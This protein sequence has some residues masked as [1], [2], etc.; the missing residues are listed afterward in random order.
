MKYVFFNK[1]VHFG[2]MLTSIIIKL[3]KL[4]LATIYSEPDLTPR[5]A[6]VVDHISP[7]DYNASNCQRLHQSNSSSLD[8][9]S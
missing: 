8:D 7:R 3:H 9:L 2:K 6:N 1:M 5:D 4:H